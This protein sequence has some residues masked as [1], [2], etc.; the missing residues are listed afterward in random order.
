MPRCHVYLEILPSWKLA[1]GMRHHNRSIDYYSSNRGISFRRVY[2]SFIDSCVCVCVCVLL[3]CLVESL[4]RAS[5]P[6]TN[7]KKR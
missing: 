6:F 5:F 1:D 7:A 3:C 2:D 4:L